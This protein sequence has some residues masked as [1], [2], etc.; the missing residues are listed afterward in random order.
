MISRLAADVLPGT[1]EMPTSPF[2]TRRVLLM[3][4]FM[5]AS[6]AACSESAS[7]GQETEAE[8]L[9]SST[10]PSSQVTASN[11]GNRAIINVFS[12]NGI[13]SAAI[14]LVSGSWPDSILMRFHLQGLENLQFLYEENRI[15]VSVNTQN[16]ILQSVSMEGAAEKAIDEDSDYWMTVSFMD[17][18]GTAVNSPV[19]GGVIEVEAPA[20]FLA[21]EYS[22][23]TIN[24][25]DFYR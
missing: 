19:Q 11:E 18:Q 22:T 16:M 24:W 3:L 14:T 25:I 2:S 7:P 12:D 4:A 9:V 1:R 20:A 13:G 15:N 8:Y 6:L 17:R 5:A 10:R 21:G 23:F